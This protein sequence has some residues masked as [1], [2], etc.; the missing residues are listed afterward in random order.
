MLEEVVE[1]GEKAIV[2]TQ[3]K[4]MGDRLQ[5]HLESRLGFAPPFHHG[6]TPR[7]QR[8]TMVRVFQEDPAG[9]PVML[10]SLKAGGVGLNLTAATHVFHFDRWWNP[11]VEDQATDRTYRIG[12]TKNVQVHKLVTIGT[13]EEKIDAL[14]ESKRDLADRVVGTGEGWLTELDDDALRRLVS[15]DSDTEVMDEEENGG[16]ADGAAAK[17]REASK[18]EMEVPELPEEVRP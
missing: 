4:E 6:G 2:F 8:D 18:L 7:D 11:A 13:L 15:L 14:L 1:N 3:F 5:A 12:Q 9:P 10:L 16:R 17:V